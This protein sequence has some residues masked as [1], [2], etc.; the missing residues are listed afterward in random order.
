MDT[1]ISAFQQK[2]LKTVE[3]FKTELGKVQTGR[4]SASLVEHISVELYGQMQP[5]KN[6]A[7]IS[8]PDSK[9]ISL[10]PWDK[11]AIQ[12]IEK[13]LQ[14][15]DIN[16]MNNGVSILITLPPLTEERRKEM[17]KIVKKIAEETKVTIR[18]QRQTAM[19][20]IKKD[21]DASEDMKKGAEK[22]LQEKVDAANKEIDEISKKKEQDIMTI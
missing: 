4:A 5:L 10:Q 9:T 11:S 21:K 15:S 19:D 3:H 18:Q 14:K 1:Y 2:Y 12:P 13:A 8:I 6:V 7:S 17:V 16:P 20:E 22:K